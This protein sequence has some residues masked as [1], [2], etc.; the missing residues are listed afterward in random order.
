MQDTDWGEGEDGE[1]Y[2][3]FRMG[4]CTMSESACV[5]VSTCACV[6]MSYMSV[7]RRVC[8]GWI[9]LGKHCAVML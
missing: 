1:V 9:V 6:R 2:I 5:C 3:I 7:L 8:M 4:L